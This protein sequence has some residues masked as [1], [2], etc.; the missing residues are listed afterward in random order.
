MESNGT[1]S[2]LLS[3]L[4]ILSA[5]V[6]SLLTMDKIYIDGNLAFFVLVTA[7]SLSPLAEESPAKPGTIACNARLDKSEK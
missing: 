5:A 4:V 3:I 7:S 6:S 1:I 2:L